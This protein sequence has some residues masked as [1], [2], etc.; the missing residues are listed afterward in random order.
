M[1]R[2]GIS[3]DPY[4]NYGKPGT[5]WVELAAMAFAHG[6]VKLPLMLRFERVRHWSRTPVRS[7]RQTLSNTRLS[8]V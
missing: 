7:H 6:R 3:I 1:P 4:C 8:A 5:K 2:G